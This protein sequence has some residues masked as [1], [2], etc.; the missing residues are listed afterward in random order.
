MVMSSFRKGREV[1]IGRTGYI[2][3][4]FLHF[5]WRSVILQECKGT[6]RRQPYVDWN[7]V[8]NRKKYWTWR[9][10]ELVCSKS[11]AQMAGVLSSSDREVV[12]CHMRY[13]SFLLLKVCLIM[14]SMSFPWKSIHYAESQ[15]HSRSTQPESAF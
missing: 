4:L 15:V 13:S 1:G 6:S 12:C 2:W 5:L 11:V 10:V 3:I 8:G 14:N 9:R 7:E